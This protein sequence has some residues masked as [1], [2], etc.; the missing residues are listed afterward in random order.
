MAFNDEF[1]NSDND[2]DESLEE[3][4]QPIEESLQTNS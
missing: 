2:D 4:N 1:F 3:L